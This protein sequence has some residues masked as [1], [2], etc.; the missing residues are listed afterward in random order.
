[1]MLISTQTTARER[2]DTARERGDTARER[3]DTARER[4]D[5]ARERGDLFLALHPILGGKLNIIV[6]CPESRDLLS[7]PAGLLLS[8]SCL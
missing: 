2:G 5:T 4:G 7:A 8:I 6:N 3:G 1:M